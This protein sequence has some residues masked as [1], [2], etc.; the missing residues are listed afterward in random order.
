M[1]CKNIAEKF[2]P[3]IIFNKLESFMYNLFLFISHRRRRTPQDNGLSSETCNNVVMA[4]FSLSRLSF[5]SV[6]STNRSSVG[7]AT[8]AAQYKAFATGIKD[9]GITINQRWLLWR[10][11]TGGRLRLTRTGDVTMNRNSGCR[12]VMFVQ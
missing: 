8:R 6:R 11:T 9:Y 10:H 2:N 3:Y 7:H 12:D 4:M 5:R 1:L